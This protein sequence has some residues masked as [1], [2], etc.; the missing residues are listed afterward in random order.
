MNSF[1]IT[2]NTGDSKPIG[3]T[4][5]NNKIT[6]NLPTQI[7]QKLYVYDKS[8]FTHEASFTGGLLSNGTSVSSDKRYKTSIQ[9][10]EDVWDEFK[11]LKIVSWYD[12]DGSGNV[13]SDM[14]RT[15]V[16]AQDID[17]DFD[18]KIFNDTIWNTD[19]GRK[20]VT[21]LTLHNINLKVTQQLQQ[22]VEELKEENNKYK[23]LI[24]NMDERI[25]KLEEG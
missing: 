24:A 7:N 19:S 6:L 4:D 21:Y 17:S 2:L 13:V 11:K 23:N 12:T 8:T 25:K 15:G 22:K 10:L 20:Y 1:G 16:I 14:I 18:N 9:P 3:I 5:T